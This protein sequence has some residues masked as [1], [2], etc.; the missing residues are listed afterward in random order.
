MIQIPKITTFVCVE[1]LTLI[2]CDTLKVGMLNYR[3]EG[4]FLFFISFKMLL[5][6]HSIYFN[7]PKT[8]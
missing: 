1:Y 8:S 4:M 2:F 7:G 3:D 6:H 5:F